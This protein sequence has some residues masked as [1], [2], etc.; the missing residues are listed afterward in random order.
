MA[1]NRLRHLLAIDLLAKAYATHASPP[2]SGSP[3]GR[4]VHTTAA[5]NDCLPLALLIISSEIART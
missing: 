1:M 2:V 4:R 3:V 5:A